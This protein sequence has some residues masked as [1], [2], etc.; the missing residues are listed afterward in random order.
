MKSDLGGS[1]GLGCKHQVCWCFAEHAELRARCFA[2]DAEP[3]PRQSP[4]CPCPSEGTDS[5]LSCSEQRSP[6]PEHL[7][8]QG[9]G[10]AKGKILPRSPSSFLS[11]EPRAEFGRHT[12]PTAKWSCEIPDRCSLPSLAAEQGGKSMVLSPGLP[13]ELFEHPNHVCATSLHLF[14]HSFA[15]ACCC[16]G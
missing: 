6:G 16:A 10:L 1:A 4:S 11:R 9:K 15:L 3:Q 8:G 5:A 12:S 13:Q 2:G 14:S 7:L